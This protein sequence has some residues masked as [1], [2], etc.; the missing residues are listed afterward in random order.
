MCDDVNV[1]KSLNDNERETPSIRSLPTRW[2]QLGPGGRPNTGGDGAG[3]RCFQIIEG[4]GCEKYHLL[5]TSVP[6]TE[7][8][9]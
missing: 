2:S 7:H 5:P 1:N 4:E 3:I 6:G 8:A 9:S